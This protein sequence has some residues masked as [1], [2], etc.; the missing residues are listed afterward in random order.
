M[1]LLSASVGKKI[2]MAITG[3]VLVLFVIAHIIGNSTIYFDGLNSYAEHL[4]SLAALVW[5]NRF[6][7]LAVLAVHI[8]FG[9]S[10]TLENSAAAPRAYAVSKALRAT[11]ASKNMIWTGLVIGVFLVY[12]LLHFTFQVTNPET[13]A[14]SNMDA[15]GRPDVAA[16]VI[17]GFQNI[18]ISIIYIISM[19]ALLLHL[20]HGIQSTFQ[21]LGLNNDNTLPVF[22][23]AGSVIAY[24]LFIA[25]IL[26]PVVIV[27]GL[28]KG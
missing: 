12:H 28:M 24:I 11:F 2:L 19:A 22:E 6:V 5:A 4:H 7:M 21:S 25:F 23:K 1:K 16:M 26:I 13:A 15:A 18:T 17:A 14:L 27:I 9:I 3:Q 10:L 20:S 8:F